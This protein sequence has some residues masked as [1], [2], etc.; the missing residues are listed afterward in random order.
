LESA[1]P[2]RSER[3]WA[4]DYGGR[5]ER[6]PDRKKKGAAQ[7]SLEDV[8]DKLRKKILGFRDR[9]ELIV[10]ENT[11][12]ALIEPLLSALG[13]DVEEL[14]EVHREYKRKP[15]DKPVDYALF[16][17]REPR[18]FIEA[19]A[20]DEDLTNRDKMGIPDY[21]LCGHRWGQVVCFD[22]RG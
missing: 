19:K 21:G 20:L 10:E 3:P 2:I 18:L 17:N 22:R 9:K 5:P 1:H 7:M 11:K 16:L 15:K 6:S 4:E 8:V 14:D 13:W 12:G